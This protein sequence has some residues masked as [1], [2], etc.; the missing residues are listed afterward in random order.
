MQMGSI[1]GLRMKSNGP[2]Q[3]EIWAEASFGQFTGLYRVP[4]W[5]LG[6][7][8]RPH[9]P[10]H[11][12][13]FM[14]CMNSL[15]VVDCKGYVIYVHAGYFGNYHNS[16]CL[17]NSDLCKNWKNYFTWTKPNQP[18]EYLLGGLAY[19]GLDMFI[20]SIV[21]YR[22]EGME[23]PTPFIEVFNKRHH[24]KRVRVKWGIGGV[25]N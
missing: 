15:L 8:S 17:R 6:N 12:L 24:R 2:L 3:P 4:W 21:D 5:A 14:Y 22:E 13:F 11:K 18:E 10:E 20:L 23:E 16:R 9:V 1:Q 19:L 25:K 7:I